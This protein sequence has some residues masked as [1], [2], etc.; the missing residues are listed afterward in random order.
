NKSKYTRAFKVKK[1][2]Q[3]WKIINCKSTAMKIEYYIKSLSKNKKELLVINPK[4]L[5]DIFSC[6]VF[7]NS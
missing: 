5:E 1:I 6:V 2:I 4:K 7:D 3:C